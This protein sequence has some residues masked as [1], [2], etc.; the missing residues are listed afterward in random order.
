MNIDSEIIAVLAENVA[1]DELVELVDVEIAAE[2][3]RSVIRV[4][5]D[6]EGGVRLRDCESFSRKLGAIL[7]VE[8]PLAGPY[9]LEVSSPGMDRRLRQPKHFAACKGKRVKI[10]LSAPVDGSR[11]FRGTLLGSDEEGIELDRDGR[12]FRLPYRLMRKANLVVPQN[13]LFGKGMRRR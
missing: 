1:Q 8:D 2:G 4:F 10:S 12:T 13:E 7:D 6:R 5:I 3:P 9:S 11:N